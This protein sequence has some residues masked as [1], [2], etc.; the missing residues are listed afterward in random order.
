MKQKKQFKVGEIIKIDQNENRVSV[1]IRNEESLV[2]NMKQEIA[3]DHTNDFKIYDIVRVWEDKKIEKSSKAKDITMNEYKQIKANLNKY[4]L[5]QL[6][7][8][9][10]DLKNYVF[11]KKTSFADQLV[12]DILYHD[13]NYMRNPL[14]YSESI[15][16]FL[17]SQYISNYF[18]EKLN[19]IMDNKSDIDISKLT[20]EEI[21]DLM[22]SLI[23]KNNHSLSNL[24]LLYFFNI[25]TKESLKYFNEKVNKSVVAQLLL[26]TNEFISSG[27]YYISRGDST[28]L[29]QIEQL[30]NIFEKLWKINKEDANSFYKYVLKLYPLDYMKFIHTFI[31]FAHLNY[32]FDKIDFII[33][34]KDN[35][36]VK[37][38]TEVKYKFK[39]YVNKRGVL[40][41]SN[42]S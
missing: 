15:N 6:I 18:N 31:S 27:E 25:D 39:N 16:E 37:D 12:S 38:A 40:Y 34:P 4:N 35:E 5:D 41:E 13:F 28:P 19:S 20:C 32:N 3:V 42:A 21:D 26:D 33:Q 8:Y 36:K 29:I 9:H 23:N 14:K 10:Q 30:V 11:N 2:S 7:E 22:K 1:N 17:K 24:F